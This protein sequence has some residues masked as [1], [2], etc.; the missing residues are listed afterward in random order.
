LAPYSELVSTG[1]NFYRIQRAKS[2]GVAHDEI[3]VETQDELFISPD[4]Q[5]RI[6]PRHERLFLPGYEQR[7]LELVRTARKNG[8]EPVLITQ[9]MLAG[10]GIDAETGANL[11]TAR[12]SNLNG[13]VVWKT[14]E[15]YNDVVRAVGGSENV[16]VIDLATQLPKDSSLFSDFYHFTNVG[17]AAVG[18]IVSAG[19]CE[20]LSKKFE[21]HFLGGCKLLP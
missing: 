8:I 14:L 4:E 18:S 19:L 5:R 12:I 17:A 13:R 11:A 16:F 3:D 6:Q 10:E 21:S 7:V 20:H 15:L 1:L 9:P 2:L